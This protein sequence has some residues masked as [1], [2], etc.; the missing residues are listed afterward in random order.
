MENLVATFIA[1]LAFVVSIVTT[2]VSIGQ[3][4]VAQHQ[5]AASREALRTQNLM[6]LFTFM[7]Q[8]EY[9]DARNVVRSP[10]FDGSDKAS[11]YKVCSHFDFAGV[12]VR[13]DLVDAHLFLSYWGDTLR[14]FNAAL[15]DFLSQE[16]AKGLTGRQMWKD[17]AWLLDQA[18]LRSFEQPTTRQVTVTGRIP[19][20]GVPGGSDGS[21]DTTLNSRPN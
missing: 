16:Q 19:G 15:G 4:K 14:V 18:A 11:V 7:H 21:E 2:W 6:E 5:L 12:V 8:S 13:A 1:G 9:R 20:R 3:W 17:F 10:K